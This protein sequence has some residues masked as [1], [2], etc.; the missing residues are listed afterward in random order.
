MRVRDTVPLYMDRQMNYFVG[1]LKYA[2]Q[3]EALFAFTSE[4]MNLYRPNGMKRLGVTAPFVL[5]FAGGFPLS[6]MAADNAYS[7]GSGLVP[8]Q[9]VIDRPRPEVQALGGRVGQFL[10]FPSL[11]L[12]EIY[13]D[14]LF[15]T[16]SGEVDDLI[17]VVKPSVQAR[18]DWNN[19]ELSVFGWAA[20]ALHAEESDENWQ[21]FAVGSDYR[22]DILRGSAA[23]GGVKFARLHEERS[24]P[25]DVNGREPTTYT[26]LEP[27]IGG[28]HRFGRFNAGAT[29]SLRRFDFDDASAAGGATINNDDRDRNEWEGGLRLGYEV[30]PE[31]EAFVRAAYN[32]SDYD[33]AR[34]DA[35]VDRNSD[36]YEISI[37]S[38]LEFTDLIVGEAFIG[39]RTQSFDDPTL[40]SASGI[41]GGLDVT[42]N[43]T[44]LTSVT[45]S[46]VRT[47]E[48]TTQVN[49]AGYFAT[50][51]RIEVDHELLRNLLIGASASYDR[52]DF[53]GISRVD[54]GYG[55]GAYVKYLTNRYLDLSA[56][57]QYSRRD[58]DVA[59]ESFDRNTFLVQ[60]TVKY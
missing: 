31:H 29:G 34:D 22:H 16:S 12:T 52:N 19:H 30:R 28:N 3:L 5:L 14:N 46:V 49:A 25:D 9:S 10:V 32:V 1:R 27:T 57:Y 43:V 47:V 15:A 45:A 18:S 26:L 7:G 17:T 59:T 53:E 35:G 40:S 37:G 54:N 41:G 23:R 33:D 44:R 50:R 56:R 13:D 39:Y 2:V 36:G 58:S 21:D 11:S 38:R 4:Y 51:T 55:G 20:A 24:S 8:G 48:E 6:S 42:W 60:A